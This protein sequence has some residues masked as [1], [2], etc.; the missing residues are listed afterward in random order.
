MLSDRFPLCQIFARVLKGKPG[1]GRSDREADAAP[2]LIF[3]LPLVQR[4][5]LQRP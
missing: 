1:R 5:A 4:T 3:E 2:G